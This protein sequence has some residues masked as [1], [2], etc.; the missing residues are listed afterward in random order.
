MA[1]AY[2]Y[3]YVGSNLW[4]WAVKGAAD[5]LCGLLTG[6]YNCIAIGDLLQQCGDIGWRYYLQE[7]IGC[8]V[9]KAFYFRRCVIESKAFLGAEHAYIGLIKPFFF[10]DAEVVF[11]VEV[12][13]THDA[14]E[15]IYPIWVIKWHA[16]AVGLGRET[17]QEQNLSVL[18]QKRFKRVLLYIHHS[19]N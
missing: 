19:Q 8:V 18:G 7:C 10:D 13:Q 3:F 15:V 17:A 12:Y 1:I 14:P 11:V 5:D 6:G 2:F 16:P 9:F 4:D